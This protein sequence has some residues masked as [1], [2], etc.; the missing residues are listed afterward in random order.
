MLGLLSTGHTL[1]SFHSL[2][3]QNF[4]F[5]V[6]TLWNFVEISVFF[7]VLFLPHFAN[8]FCTLSELFHTFACFCVHIAFIV[9]L[10][11][12]FFL[13][14]L[15]LHKFANIGNLFFKYLHPL[16]LCW[17][18]G[19]NF[20]WVCIILHTFVCFTYLWILLHSFLFCLFV[21][22]FYICLAYFLIKLNSLAYL[23]MHLILL[24]KFN[25]FSLII[26]HI[27]AHFMY[28]MSSYKPVC[29]QVFATPAL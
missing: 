20:A 21:S 15:F 17:K 23:G 3:K 27:F 10:Q 18:I 28:C 12:F 4:P 5:F 16:S 1:S 6:K 8:W 9:S 24:H 29:R 11:Y 2:Q 14:L 25:F 7:S 22:D 19:Y 13:F 26:L